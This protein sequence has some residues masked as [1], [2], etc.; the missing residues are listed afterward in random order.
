MARRTFQPREEHTVFMFKLREFGSDLSSS[1]TN[2]GE[3]AHN[4]PRGKMCCTQS[5]SA[6]VKAYLGLRPA[7]HRPQL[8]RERINNPNA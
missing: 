3:P 7:N 8:P 1:K 2:F 4:P 6:P 5:L